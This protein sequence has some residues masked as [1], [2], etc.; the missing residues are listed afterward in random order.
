MRAYVRNG[1]NAAQS[2]RQHSVNVVDEGADNIATVGLIDGD[3]GVQKMLT[4]V[5]QVVAQR[6][7]GGGSGHGETFRVC[8]EQFTLS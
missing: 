3:I 7:F 4:G 1:E 5:A 8:A 2:R 6:R